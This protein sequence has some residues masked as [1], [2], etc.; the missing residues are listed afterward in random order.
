L[1]VQ[2]EKDLSAEIAGKCQKLEKELS[3]KLQARMVK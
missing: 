2:K 3:R 1:N